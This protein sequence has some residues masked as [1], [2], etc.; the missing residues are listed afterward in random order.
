[1]KAL[2]DRLVWKFRHSKLSITLHRINRR[3]PYEK[4]SCVNYLI[5]AVNL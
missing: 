1:M 3:S 5:L 2:I 4:V